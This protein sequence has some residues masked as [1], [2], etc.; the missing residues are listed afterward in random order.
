VIE[1][2]QPVASQIHAEAQWS[3]PV[4]STNLEHR[5]AA[6]ASRASRRFWIRW[7]LG[8]LFVATIVGCYVLFRRY[9][10]WESIREDIDAW[11]REAQAAPLWAAGTFFLAYAAVTALS[12]PVATVLGLVAGALFGRVLGTFLVSGASTVG[13]TVAFLI[14]RYLLHDWVQ[15]RYASR[16]RAIN[17]GIE[18]DG[19][20]YL[21][22]LR[23]TPVVPFFLINLGMGLT[24]MR[25]RTFAGVSWIGMLPGTF[26]YVNAGTALATIESPRDVLSPV[27]AASLAA[28]GLVP[29]VLRKLI[30]RRV[31]RRA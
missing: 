28:V 2:C 4:P 12:L 5:D 26:L 7:S 6:D 18:R 9:W 8:V 13:A 11:Q 30:Q 15:N 17:D 25:A 1:F 16:L 29:L 3:M 24:P 31:G 14:S 20:F 21:F 22:L 27:V 23:L 19:P 10:V